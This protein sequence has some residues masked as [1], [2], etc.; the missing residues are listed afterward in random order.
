MSGCTSV[1]TF[2]SFP[3]YHETVEQFTYVEDGPDNKFKSPS[4]TLRDGGDCEDFAILYRDALI[5]SGISPSEID[6]VFGYWDD[7]Y[8]AMV[9][10]NGYLFDDKQFFWSD[11]RFI[12]DRIIPSDEIPPEHRE[13]PATLIWLLK[14]DAAQRAIAAYTLQWEAS[15]DASG[16]SWR[17]FA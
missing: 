2:T 4:E 14:G 7:Q 16:S 12:I 10:Y 11:L 17:R 3:I 13:Y 6:F 1:D 9:R 15:N 8:H 5:R